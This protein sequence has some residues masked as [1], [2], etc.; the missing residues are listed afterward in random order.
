MDNI[1]EI[2][3]PNYS[4]TKYET[5]FL[6]N[7]VDRVAIFDLNTW[8]PTMWNPYKLSKSDDNHTI[9]CTLGTTISL[10]N[11]L[12]SKPNTSPKI[13]YYLTLYMDMHIPL[14]IYIEDSG[15]HT[16]DAL[17]SDYGEGAPVNEY[18][19]SIQKVFHQ[20]NLPDVLHYIVQC[21]FFSDTRSK[22]NPI[23]HLLSKS[24][25]QR[26]TI[27]NLREIV[28]NY[29]RKHE[30]VYEFVF[31]CLKCSL[32]GLYETCTERPPLE[33]RV[34]LVRKFKSITK[35]QMLQWMLR[36]HQQLMFY[37]IKEFLIYGV[38]QI[39]S[40]Y[41][42]I[43]QRYYWDKFESCVVRA[44]NTVRKC[45]CME[46]NIMDFN[47]VEMQLSVINKQQVHHLYRP[48]RHHFSHA[49]MMECEKLDD[50][51][52]VDYVH[53]E[54][55]AEYKEIIY[56]MAI[57]TPGSHEVQ[58]DWLQYFKVSPD[59]IKQLKQI[60]E[61]YIQEGSKSNLK[62]LL[63]GLSRYNFEA[64]RDF[65]DVFDRKMNCRVFTLPKHIYIQQYKA[66]RR[67]HN[68]PDGVPL[69]DDIGNT[70]LCLACKQFKGFINTNDG[71]T[72]KNLYAFG[73]SKVLVDDWE[74]KL[75]CGKRCDK[76][77]GKKRHHYVPEYS[78]FMNIEEEQLAKTNRDRNRKRMAKEKRKE[79]KNKICS[80]SELVPINLLGRLLQFYGTLYTVC[81]SCGNFMQMTG[82]FF[83]ENGF[84]CGC[85][86]QHGRLYTAVSCEWCHAI[87]GNEAWDPI[88][89]LDDT[90][91]EP[92][93]RNIY[94]CQTCH[95]P[96][97]RNAEGRLALSIIKKGLMN[98]WKRLQ[99]PG[100]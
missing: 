92:K 24:L 44:M 98:R 36:D 35:A 100:S 16:D 41:E 21:S 4:A 20:G 74:M 40:I 3:L 57:R 49:V 27:R 34:K 32:L 75:Y 63:S 69:G 85:C 46:S 66:L 72:I 87:R 45:V 23:V 68:V 94:L 48:A 52:C 99:H 56:K 12:L 90:Q 53:K 82:T 86:I 9:Y 19:P 61:I 64:V 84:Y 43:K 31:G 5:V 81:P 25:P 71:K 8:N 11:E 55:P 13:L 33:V 67:K 28:S 51:N 91:E 59:V 38:K 2:L 18:L 62:N 89:V 6:G 88:S 60:Q 14:M 58:Y 10:L 83:T 7:F 26:C 77:D 17:L 78:S 65:S 95:K 37:I 42:E 79:L 29:C 15:N 1:A 22:S 96:W 39:P 70:L 76:V 97:I 47:G 80:S 93:E 73:H 50:A 54:F 30:D